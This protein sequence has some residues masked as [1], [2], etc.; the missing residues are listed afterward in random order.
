LFPAF[1]S[2]LLDV[3]ASA[4]KLK[5]PNWGADNLTQF[6]RLTNSNQ[7]GNFA[8]FPEPYALMR[9]VN[10]CYTK[11]GESL[12]NPKPMMTG[13]MFL[14]SQYAYKTTV[15]MA[16]AGQVV[17]SFVMMRS[18]LEYAGYALVIFED[19]ILENVFLKRHFDPSSMKMQKDKFRFS[20]VANVI[21]NFDQELAKI[22]QEFYNRSIDFGGHPNPNAVLNALSEVDSSDGI[23]K[24]VTLAMDTDE[25]TLLHAM[26]CTAQVGLTALLI[27]QHIFKSK[28]ELL[29]LPAKIELLKQ[30][31]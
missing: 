11:A 23:R 18:C 24:F 5:M 22:F 6:L 25:K 16:L 29:G 10:D 15:G 27:F 21:S 19:P 26:K 17:E 14:R 30:V 20:E 8:R 13:P 28:F 9:Q 12:V 31:L 1:A 7:I 3:L 2:A 4:E